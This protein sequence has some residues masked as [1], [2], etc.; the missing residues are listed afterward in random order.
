MEAIMFG[1]C[2]TLFAAGIGYM[3]ADVWEYLRL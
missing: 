1:L 3:V 2:M